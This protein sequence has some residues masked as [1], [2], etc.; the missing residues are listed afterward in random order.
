[1]YTTVYD[2][3]PGEIIKGIILF[4]YSMRVSVANISVFCL[5]GGG[6]VKVVVCDLKLDLER[7][8]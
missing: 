6:G 1:M 2:A 7:K 4:I 8:L 3:Y 5:G